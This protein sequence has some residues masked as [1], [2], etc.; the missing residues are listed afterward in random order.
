MQ[1]LK[2]AKLKTEKSLVALNCKNSDLQN[3][4]VSVLEVFRPADL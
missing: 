2:N 4:R 1:I 3:D